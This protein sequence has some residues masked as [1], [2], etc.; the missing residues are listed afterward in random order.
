MTV[1]R[2]GSLIPPRER[3]RRWVLDDDVYEDYRHIEG[4]HR[5]HRWFPRHEGIEMRDWECPQCGSTNTSVLSSPPVTNWG[6]FLCLDCSAEGV[7]SL[8]CHQR[9]PIHLTD[10][11]DCSFGPDV[12]DE[13]PKTWPPDAFK[14]APLLRK[15]DSSANERGGTSAAAINDVNPSTSSLHSSNPHNQQHG[16]RM[17]DHDPTVDLTE[18]DDILESL[19]VSLRRELR[20]SIR[21]KVDTWETDDGHVVEEFY[22]DRWYVVEGAP[23]H[24]CGGTSTFHW[25]HR[26]A[27]DVGHFNCDDCGTNGETSKYCEHPGGIH[28]DDL[29]LCPF[30]FGP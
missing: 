4:D 8:S 27:N 6:E 30:S 16:E 13:T 29:F 23:C 14:S 5:V 15:G 21:E 10:H 17:P 1:Q 12:W 25:T 7:W 24:V 28:H 2:H 26:T 20:N 9:I 22:R 3:I 18:V 19:F 11:C